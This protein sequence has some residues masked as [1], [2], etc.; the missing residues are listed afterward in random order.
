[1]NDAEQ[2][3]DT[4]AG[5]ILYELKHIPS[6]GETFEWRGFEFEIIEMDKE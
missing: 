5:F 2:E 4:L 3:F 6:T 1:M